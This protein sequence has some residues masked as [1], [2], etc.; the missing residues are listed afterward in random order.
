MMA[1]ALAA[2]DSNFDFRTDVLSHRWRPVCFSCGCDA[3]H[4]GLIC[5]F[6]FARPAAL[7]VF[8]MFN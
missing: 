5:G 7:A 8:L 3:R 6:H 2:V 4:I 1:A